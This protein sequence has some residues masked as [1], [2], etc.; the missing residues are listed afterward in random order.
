MFCSIRKSER[1][2]ERVFHHLQRVFHHLQAKHMPYDDLRH[3]FQSLKNWRCMDILY[4][5]G[6]LQVFVKRLNKYQLGKKNPKSQKLTW[7]EKMSFGF[8]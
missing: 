3:R 7:K 4:L 6:L 1:A 5:T 8:K 2:E